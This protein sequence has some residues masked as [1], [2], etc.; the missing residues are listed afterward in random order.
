MRLIRPLVRLIGLLFPSNSNHKDGQSSVADKY[1]G[2][3]VTS[4]AARQLV[5]VKEDIRL[6]NLEQVIPYSQARDIILKNPDHIVALECPCRASRVEPCFPLDVCLIVG[7]PFAG[8]IAEN[9]PHRARWVD[10]EEA[11]DILDVE[12]MRDHVQHAFF[13]ET[14]LGR[15]YGICNCCN[16]CCGAMRAM[17]NGTPMLAASGYTSIVSLDTCIG[18]GD[19]SKIC[20]FGAIELFGTTAEVDQ[21]KC[22]GCGVCVSKCS[23]GAISLRLEPTMGKPLEIYNLIEDSREVPVL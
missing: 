13:K 14:M 19:C 16:C 5:T 17:R 1:H 23:E 4:G 6:E 12:N 22:M 3:V 8:F 11:C 20:P 2:K 15:S 10:S 18:C 7:E 9:D 21:Q